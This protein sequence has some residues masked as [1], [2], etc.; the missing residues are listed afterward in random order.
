M[1]WL[2]QRLK[3][4]KMSQADLSFQLER[5]GISKTRQAIASWMSKDGNPVPM[6]GTP[7][8]AIILAE[9]LGW[10]VTEML[11]AAGYP[12][13]E[14]SVKIPTELLPQIVEF[15]KLDAKRLSLVIKTIAHIMN[16]QAAMDDDEVSN[17]NDNTGFEADGD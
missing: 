6:L 1:H 10:S 8:E 17:A 14:N 3:I 15:A 7:T 16:L 13:V 12:I 5:H 4:L 11:L 2:R 9:I